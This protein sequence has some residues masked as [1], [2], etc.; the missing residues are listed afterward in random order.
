[1]YKLAS[2]STLASTC[3]A[4]LLLGACADDPARAPYQGPGGDKDKDQDQDEGNASTGDSDGGRK[5]GAADNSSKS[6]GSRPSSNLDAGKSDAS[7]PNNGNGNGTDTPANASCV[8]KPNEDG[9][10]AQ[11]SNDAKVQ[12]AVYTYASDG[13][14]I[15]PLT[16][17]TA[18][19]KTS[20]D[21]KLCV[22]GTAA[23]VMEMDYAKY[24][25]AG[26]AFDVCSASSSDP[27]PM[28]KYT[29]ASCPA[30]MDLLG[31]KFKL[32]GK[33]IP[34]NLRVTFK[35]AGRDESTFVIAKEGANEALFAKGT[36]AYSMTAPPAD[37]SKVEAVQFAIPTTESDTTP[38]DFCVEQI[39]LL[40]KTGTCGDGSGGSNKGDGGGGNDGGNGNGNGNASPDG[41]NGNGNG[42]PP[43]PAPACS[44]SGSSWSTNQQWGTRAYGKYKLRN[45]IWGINE[46]YQG[47]GMQTLW[48]NGSRCW[49]V[50][51]Q[52]QDVQK[53]QVK[54]Y[55]NAQR[56]WSI[57]DDPSPN[58]G[59]PIRVSEI[60]KGRI[61]WKMQ[62]SENG[63]MWGLWDIYFHET[64]NAPPKE[65]EG[66]AAEAH[67]NL[68]IQQFIVEDSNRWMIK[69]S[70]NWKRVTIGE[71]TYR[72]RPTNPNGSE[73]ERGDVS[74]PSWSRNQIKLYVDNLN[75]NTLGKK[76][77]TI[78][79]KQ[80]IDWAVQEGSLKNTD[81]LV[82]IQ[83][84][85]EIVAGG[86]YV[87]EDYWTAINDEAEGQ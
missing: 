57:H 71:H 67:V 47:I 62:A 87:T 5:D 63:R 25:G 68:M 42:N 20:G 31:I 36:V 48:A 70:D 15:E 21:G 28:K 18:P 74:N 65:A 35:E 84:G 50:D 56:G 78:D 22:K 24:Y 81:Y 58:S 16:T 7:R 43:P 45:N 72:H 1:M 41:G 14:T 26:L 82:G 53:G 77:M 86:T 3:A 2:R 75:G 19:F 9:W 40:T 32:S 54:S 6:D 27:D 49:G 79:L 11:A 29:V 46:G 44:K 12:G 30:G 55:P 4:L 17:A 64:P 23:Q 51:A 76:D 66:N 85:W 8:L 80:L 38:F 52:H 10:V 13:S 37:P 73:Q 34:S 83:A 61:R 33:T 59:L 60:R 69:D 39:Q